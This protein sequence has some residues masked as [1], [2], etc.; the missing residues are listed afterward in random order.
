MINGILKRYIP[1]CTLCSVLVN[2]LIA[3][4]AK[5]P[6]LI[7]VAIPAVKIVKIIIINGPKDSTKF[8]KSI[9][10]IA[11][12][13]LN[14]TKIRAGL[15]AASGIIKKIGANSIEAKNNSDVVKEVNP[16]LPPAS[17]PEEDSTKVVIV[18]HPNTDPITVPKAST[19]NGFW[20]S[21]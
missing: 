9:L 15:V 4:S 5:I 19:I 13:I 21:G 10:D 17:T 1:K 3:T 20:I 2:V 6:A 11:E 16:V 12:I 7:P 8:E 14:P 18:V